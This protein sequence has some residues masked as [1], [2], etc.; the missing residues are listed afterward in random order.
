MNGV[1]FKE[2]K[3]GDGFVKK[4]QELNADVSVYNV[5]K[6][7][8]ETGRFRALKHERD[9]AH[10]PH[11]FWDSD[12]AKWLES[13]AYILAA[14][15]DEKLKAIV[16]ETVDDICAQQMPC[17]YFNSYY[18]VYEPENIFKNRTEHELYCAGHLIE[19]AVALKECEI[20][21]AHV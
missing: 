9:D 14:R 19:A 7:F 8:E 4:L 10:K 5:Y 12:V 13:A 1:D 16:D 18:Q 15:G 3:I 20:G 21:R 11:I 2:V 17:G 6:R